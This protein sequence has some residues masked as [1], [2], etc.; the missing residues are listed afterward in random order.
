[1]TNMGMPGCNLHFWVYA[2]R[3]HHV[4]LHVHQQLAN[5]RPMSGGL[6]P[7][8]FLPSGDMQNWPGVHQ[9]LKCGCY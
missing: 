8:N 6:L 2:R 1:M 3:L 7:E 9:I 4:R 5:L